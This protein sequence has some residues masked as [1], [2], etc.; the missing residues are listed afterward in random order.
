MLEYCLLHSAIRVTGDYRLLPESTGTDVYEDVL[1]F[2]NWVREALPGILNDV[3]PGVEA[4]LSKIL[5]HGESAGGTISL[6]SGFS[7]SPGFVK[8][9]VAMYPGID[10]LNN[11]PRTEPI[12]G[13]PTL[14]PAI[15]EDHLEAMEPGKIVTSAFPP[16]RADLMISVAQQGRLRSFFGD[17][18]RLDLHKVLNNAK[19]MPYTLILHKKEDSAVPTS[20][21]IKWTEMASRK[22]GAD[23]ID[24]HLGPGEHGFDTELPLSSPWLQDRLVRVTELWLG[25]KDE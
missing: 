17:D 25:E 11:T 1:D 10:I 2:W 13:I 7:Q 15:L 6:L 16:E 8:A 20:G 9:V 24:L 3:R 5:V 22:F 18:E 4:D 14:P 19:N 23:K 12:L 21:S